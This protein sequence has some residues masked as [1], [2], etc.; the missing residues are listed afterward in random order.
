MNLLN[1]LEL[2][3]P[4]WLFLLFVTPLFYLIAIRSPGHVTFSALRLLP[5]DAQVK[6]LKLRLA[7]L[8]A[9]LLTAAFAML[10]ISASGPRVGNKDTK[11]EKQGIAIMMVVDTSGSMRALDLST[12]KKE[13]TRLDIVKRLFEDF[14]LG[15]S[16]LAG[17]GNDSIGIIR[18][19]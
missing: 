6:S 1:G 13:E 19:A 18:F 8:P 15:A 14:V 10:V 5:A 16:D 17:R 9:A 2:R 4:L 11:I 12:S 7:W 3:E